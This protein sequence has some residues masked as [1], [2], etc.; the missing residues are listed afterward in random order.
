[1]LLSREWRPQRRGWIAGRSRLRRATVTARRYRSRG[2]P[3]RRE[4]TVDERAVDD[5]VYLVE[6]VAKDGDAD[7]RRNGGN[8]ESDQNANGELNNAV[9]QHHHVQYANNSQGAQEDCTI[10]QPLELLALIAP[11]L[12]E[13][14]D[15]RGGDHHHDAYK[16]NDQDIQAQ[17]YDASRPL[18]TRRVARG[19]VK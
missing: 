17:L 14:H 2:R 18:N 7:G 8:S 3:A 6:A 10:D 1:M 9:M 4:G 13:A 12:P 15:H 5:Y 16:G 19:H 11:R